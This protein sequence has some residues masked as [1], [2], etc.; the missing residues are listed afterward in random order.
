MTLTDAF[1]PESG[2][3]AMYTYSTPSTYTVYMRCLNDITEFQT[4]V[5]VTSQ[6]NITGRSTSRH[7]T[8]S[9]VGRDII[10][11]MFI[12]FDCTQH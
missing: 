11:N 10:V 4:S 9:Q 5:N 1:T 7:N 6:Y 2:V 12:E 8:I 3:Q